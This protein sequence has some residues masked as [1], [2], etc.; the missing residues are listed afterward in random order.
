M[1]T[2]SYLTGRMWDVKKP[3]D[4]RGIMGRRTTEGALAV[5]VSALVAFEVL[6]STDPDRC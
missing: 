1:A 3:H 4:T 6:Q 2:V 5:L